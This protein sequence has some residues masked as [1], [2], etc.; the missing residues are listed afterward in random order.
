MPAASKPRPLVIERPQ[1]SLV[2]DRGSARSFEVVRS[3]AREFVVERHS[4]PG[5]AGQNGGLLSE[6]EITEI[7]EGQVLLDRSDPLSLVNAILHPG[8]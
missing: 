6:Q 8:L 3:K 2:L 7:A 4:L 5:P 1:K